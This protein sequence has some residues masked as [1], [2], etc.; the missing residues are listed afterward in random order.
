MVRKRVNCETIKDLMLPSSHR[1]LSKF[2]ISACTCNEEKATVTS[3]EEKLGCN[4][5]DF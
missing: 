2:P 5:A 3:G 4:E 1:S